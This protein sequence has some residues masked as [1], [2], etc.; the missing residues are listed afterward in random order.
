MSKSKNPPPDPQ[1]PDVDDAAEARRLQRQGSIAVDDLRILDNAT[2]DGHFLTLVRKQLH[3][4]ETAELVGTDIADFPPL[5][6][7]ENITLAKQDVLKPWPDKWETYFDFVHQRTALSIAGDV[8]R[9]V[10]TIWR[11]I[12]LL[13]PGGWIQIVDTC[14][15]LGEIKEAEIL[16][17]AGEG[18]LRDIGEKQGVSVLGKGAASKEL[19]EMGYEEVKGM[20]RAGIMYLQNMPQEQRPMTLQQLDLLWRDV[21][22][23]GEV[24]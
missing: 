13:K 23:G 12:A 4:P 24:G 21:L 19:E 5:E 2:A 14:L 11:L 18:L 17:R 16:R 22:R 8:D 3:H 1:Y 10:G 9:A 15:M 6:L 7:P 20:Y